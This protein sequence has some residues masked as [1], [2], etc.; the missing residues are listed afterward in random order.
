[1][2]P[3][4]PG[5]CPKKPGLGHVWPGLGPAW[6]AYTISK[7]I[8]D[9][10]PRKRYNYSINTRHFWRA[11]SAVL[12]LHSGKSPYLVKKTCEICGG[13]KASAGPLSGREAADLICANRQVPITRSRQK[14]RLGR[15]VF[16][17]KIFQIF[18]VDLIHQ[19]FRGDK[20][21]QSYEKKNTSPASGSGYAAHLRP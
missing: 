8:V 10:L 7:Q 15:R 21:E 12:S 2:D 3:K 13:T 9:T 5:K 6:E 16:R 14:G 20:E 1:M 19:S 11:F 4:K 17:A 18:M